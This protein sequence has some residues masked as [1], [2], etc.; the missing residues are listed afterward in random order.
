MQTFVD[1]FGRLVIPKVIREHLGIKP[2]SVI[3]IE[4]KDETVLL[5]IIGRESPVQQKKGVLVFNGK[6]TNDL[7]NAIKN[8]RD[9]HL[10]DLFW[11]E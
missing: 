3:E 2:G 10:N 4:E 7:E 1:K 9:K 6:A 5:K 11:E 8:E